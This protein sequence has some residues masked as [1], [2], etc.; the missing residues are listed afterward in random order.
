MA[1]NNEYLCA[2]SAFAVRSTGCTN[3]APIA[4]KSIELM[5]NRYFASPLPMTLTVGIL[6]SDVPEIQAHVSRGKM[7]LLSAEEYFMAFWSAAAEGMSADPDSWSA[8]I[9]MSSA[10]IKVADSIEALWNLATCL[11][12]N[13]TEDHAALGRT[14]YQRI[15]DLILVKQQEEQG[16]SAKLTPA[17]LAKIYNDRVKVASSAAEPVNPSLADMAVTVHDRALC[18]P[19]VQACVREMEEYRHDSIFCHISKMQTI[20]EKARTPDRIEWTFLMLADSFKAGNLLPEAIGLRALQGRAKNAGGMGTVDVVCFKKSL[21]HYLCHTWAPEN[22]VAEAVVLKLQEITASPM[23]WRKHQGYPN[24]PNLPDVTWRGGWPSSGDELLALVEDTAIFD[25]P[26]HTVL[27][28][29]LASLRLLLRLL[30][31]LSVRQCVPVRQWWRECV[32][33]ARMRV[34]ACVWVHM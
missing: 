1:E 18:I 33:H 3:T 11:R 9:R 5:K 6:E 13:A 25:L 8:A 12:E 2:L 24:S 22:S 4:A 34:R 30:L 23:V 19:A 7:L 29:L 28:P 26:A 20:V 14:G 21:C 32:A 10:T 17:A 15:Y 31:S 16:R 27:E